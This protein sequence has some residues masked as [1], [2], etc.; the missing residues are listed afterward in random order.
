MRSLLGVLVFGL[1]VLGG[2]GANAGDYLVVIDPGHGGSRDAGSQTERSLSAAN[3]ATSPSGLKEKDLTL[4]LTLEILAQVKA[5][6]TAHPGAK[7][8]CRLTRTG[9]SNPDFIQRTEVC[10]SARPLPLAIVSIHFNASSGG[11]AI[12]SLAVVH[13][14]KANANYEGDRAFATGLIR[15]TSEAVSKFV[16]NSRPREPISDA[17]L[18]GGAGSNFFHQLAKH[19]ELA[20]VPKCFLE[21]EFI[22]RPDVDKALLQPRKTTFPVIARAIAEY[23]YA[24]CK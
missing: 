3:N 18:H 15:A 7:L 4:E 23:L 8:E 11:S 2:F 13:H 22:D 12:G 24:Q 6:A 14:Q 21:V 1:L 10:T 20:S 19:R 17:H 16:P 5:L 9:D